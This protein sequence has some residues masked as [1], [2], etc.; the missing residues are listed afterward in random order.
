MV[1]TKLTSV[2][3]RDKEQCI[4]NL[5]CCCKNDVFYIHLMPF[6]ENLLPKKELKVIPK[7]H[8]SIFKSEA[9]NGFGFVV[10]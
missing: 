8:N 7:K 4:I 6:N 2:L 1:G 10:I 9:V 5:R 3:V